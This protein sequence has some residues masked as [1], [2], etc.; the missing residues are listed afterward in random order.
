MRKLILIITSILSFLAIVCVGVLQVNTPASSLD[1]IK[2]NIGR[3]NA[4]SYDDSYNEE[5]T[6]ENSVTITATTTGGSG[7][8]SLDWNIEW[9]IAN[10]NTVT[11][12]V[13]LDVADDT[14]SATVTYIKNFDTQIKVMVSSKK[15]SSINDEI[16]INCTSKN[17]EAAGYNDWKD[18]MEENNFELI[19]NSFN[20]DI[21]TGFCISQ[22]GEEI[23][24]D[25]CANLLK[26]DELICSFY[27]DEL[28]FSNYGT[29]S[30]NSYYIPKPVIYVDDRIES[31]IA[32][33]SADYLGIDLDYQS[34]YEYNIS[35][36]GTITTSLNDY[37]LSM[38]NSGTLVDYWHERVQIQLDEIVLEYDLDDNGTKEE[39][40]ANDLLLCW[41]MNMGTVDDHFLFIEK[42]IEIEIEHEFND[43]DFYIYEYP[44]VTEYIPIYFDV[45]NCF[46]NV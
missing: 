36:N 23:N 31:Y 33:F 4:Y 35:Q 6:N 18:G 24:V 13:T 9:A 34:I 26:K 43:G 1:S 14:L 37:I 29:E 45:A 16:T 11:D 39:Y 42:N 17:I 27:M 2:L 30:N 40:L 38:F 20:N 8:N 5:Y 3:K 7:V 12:Y 15:D 22:I 19:I 21:P 32:S 25:A 44:Q 41:L 28:E 10:S 46:I